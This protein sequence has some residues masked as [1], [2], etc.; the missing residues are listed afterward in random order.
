MSVLPPRSCGSRTCEIELW[1]TGQ[2]AVVRRQTLRHD[3]VGHDSLRPSAETLVGALEGS[4]PSTRNLLVSRLQWPIGFEAEGPRLGGVLF[5]RAEPSIEIGQLSDSGTNAYAH[6]LPPDAP[7]L[8]AA[9]AVLELSI[10]LVQ[11]AIA[12]EDAGITFAGLID[13]STEVRLGQG[14]KAHLVIGRG[15]SPESSCLGL[16]QNHNSNTLDTEALGQL[17]N[18]LLAMGQD[19]WRSKTQKYLSAL[20]R[21]KSQPVPSLRALGDILRSMRSAVAASYKESR[22]LVQPY[23]RLAILDLYGASTQEA[24]YRRVRGER[25]VQFEDYVDV[26]PP[27]ERQREIEWA[28]WRDDTNA[29]FAEDFRPEAT[30]DQPFGTAELDPVSAAFIT[31]NVSSVVHRALDGRLTEAAFDPLVRHMVELELV[32]RKPPTLQW[33]WG[34]WDPERGVF[35]I[36]LQIRWP[37]TWD[38]QAIR[39]ER[40]GGPSWSIHRDFEFQ[41][42]EIKD[43]VPPAS[44]RTVS[45]R[46]AWLVGVPG[47]ELLGPWSDVYEPTIPGVPRKARQFVTDLRGPLQRDTVVD[48]REMLARRSARSRR[49]RVATARRLGTAFATGLAGTATWIALRAPVGDALSWVRDLL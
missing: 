25:Q 18:N 23:A 33:E 43:L 47:R 46:L 11:L 13:S 31:G 17:L 48:D 27:V 16:I 39:V 41:V 24:K 8:T 36:S 22:A 30:S 35:P 1:D 14:L 44:D 26:A 45:Y 42:E 20:S 40:I 5:R 34:S 10:D 29:P 49:V 37:R 32:D 28:R 9:D 6:L 38:L 15:Q 7:D 4:R 2:L 21:G 3:F 12:V 19:D